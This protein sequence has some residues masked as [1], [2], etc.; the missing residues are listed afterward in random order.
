MRGGLSYDDAFM[1][2]PE[3]REVIAR[4][5]E[6]NLEIAKKTQQPFFQ[7]LVT[8]YPAFLRSAIAFCVASPGFCADLNVA[9][10][11]SAAN[12]PLA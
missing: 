11:S 7:A 9:G 12:L 6:D 4:L 10:G 5:A 2:S 3:D 1:L 8:L